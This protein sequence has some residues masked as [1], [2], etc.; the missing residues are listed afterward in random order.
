MPEEDEDEQ[1]PLM[2]KYVVNGYV[3]YAKYFEISVSAYDENGAR[4]KVNS[5]DDSELTENSDMEYEGIT[6]FDVDEREMMPCI[7]SKCA[8][9]GGYLDP[10]EE[11]DLCD[12]C[13]DENEIDYA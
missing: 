5:Q 12:V 7:N 13:K 11:Y 2:R 4:E 10:D 1:R 6:I 8:N 9:Y 3:A